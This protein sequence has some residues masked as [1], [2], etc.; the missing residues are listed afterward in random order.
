MTVYTPVDVLKCKAQ[1]TKDGHA[2][3][4]TLIP[5]IV[6][7]EGYKGLFRGMSVQA[8]RD[9]PGWGIYFYSYEVFK[10]LIYKADRLLTGRNS[11]EFKN[12]QVSLDLISGGFAGSFS[13]F[14]GY[15]ID[16]IKT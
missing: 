14:I 2:R 7:A 3:Y 16:I 10:V 4:R 1:A 13:W 11:L 9:I 6:K 5:E 12:R 15:P 8:L